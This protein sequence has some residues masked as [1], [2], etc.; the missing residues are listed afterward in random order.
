MSSEIPKPA[1]I[2]RTKGYLFRRII[3]K[4]PFLVW[5]GMALLT[6]QLYQRGVRFERMNGVV[7]AETQVLAALQD[8]VIK[9]M[10]VTESG[11]SVAAD[12]LVVQLDPR[13]LEAELA[14]V[15]Q[16]TDFERIDQERKF[17]T[18]KTDYVNELAKLKAERDGA[19]AQAAVIEA[20]LEDLKTR[21]EERKIPMS[22]YTEKKTEYETLKATLPAYD[23]QIATVEATI[24]KVDGLLAK[25][26]ELNTQE[27][28]DIQSLKDQIESMKLKAISGGSVSQI[29]FSPGAAVE[30]G[31]PI[32]EIINTQVMN[33]LGFIQE[34]DAEKVSVGMPVFISPTGESAAAIYDGKITYISPEIT[35]TPDVGSSVAGRMIKG[36]E[37]TCS[38]DDPKV[39][40]LPGQSVT[41]HLERP[42]KFKLFGFGK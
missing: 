28:A 1:E 25:L 30:R 36:R 37:I 41:I 19:T 12:Q 40:L 29:Y 17:G 20:T 14:R 7:V 5:L 8:G 22:Q 34:K 35:S 26:K 4:W 32:V 3:S 13:M 11:E 31:E 18:A 24:E 6:Y 2:R 42:G 15:I 39:K 33:A 16:K 10:S 21:A 27:P 23:T 9:E 38:F